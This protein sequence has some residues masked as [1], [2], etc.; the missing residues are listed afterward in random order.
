MTRSLSPMLV[1]T[2]AWAVVLSPLAAPAE[3]A[4]DVAAVVAEMEQLD[5]ATLDQAETLFFRAL[6][7]Y[8]GERFEEAAVD[9]QKAF[10]LTN[11]R[12]LLFNIA[13][14]RERLG[15]REG[16]IKWYRAYLSTAP[17]D[18]TAVIHRVRQ[19]GGDPTPA[20][21]DLAAIADDVDIDTPLV[22]EGP[23]PWPWVAVGVGVAAAGAGAYFGLSALGD[24]SRARAA[25][26][27]QDTISLKDSAEQSA[28]LADVSFGVSAAAIGTAVVLWWLA[29]REA[30][31]DGRLEVGAAP[32]GGYLGYGIS[33]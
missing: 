15:D 29:D 6:A 10:V 19:M 5:Q 30:A 3:A 24:A 4:D 11:H 13:R 1:A 20:P 31:V 14:S 27:R 16:A 18:E 25:D 17:A 21:A 26:T 2:L 9:F 22:E 33:F 32:G 23:G 7:H 12:D 8:R 28:L